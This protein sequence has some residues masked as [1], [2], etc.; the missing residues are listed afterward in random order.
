MPKGSYVDVIKGPARRLSGTPR[1]LKIE[2]SLVE[3]LLADIEDG[4]NKDALPLLAFTLERLYLEYGAGGDLQLSQY[5]ELRGVHGSIEA[6]VERALAAAD[7]DSSIPKDRAQRLALLRRGLIP[8]LAGIDPDSG[9]P[10][11]RVARM[12]EIPTESRRLVALLVEQRLLAIDAIV[13][14]DA[15]SGLEKPIVTIEP[16]HEALLRQWDE[17]QTWLVEDRELLVVMD[18]VKRAAR[19]W[20]KN[21]RGAAW[22]TH[23]GARLKAAETLDRRPDLAASLDDVDRAYLAECATAEVEARRRIR[24]TRATLGG[25]AFFVVAGVIAW[26]FETYL[27]DGLHWITVVRPY[28]ARQVQPYVLTSAAERALKPGDGFRE[29]AS[30]AF[31]PDMIVLPVG[32]FTMGSSNTEEGRFVNEGPQHK[33]SI[34]RPFAVSK[35]DVT[36]DDWDACVAVGG[37]PDVDELDVWSR[38][39]AAD[40]RDLGR[41][42]ALCGLARGDDGQALSLAHRGG[43]GICGSRRRDDGLFMGRSNRRGEGQLHRLRQQVGQ[44]RNLAGRIV[45]FQTRSASTIWPAMSGNGCRTAG[46][47]ITAA[48]QPT[49]RS[50]PAATATNMSSGVDPGWPSRHSFDRHSE[51]SF[52]P[53]ST[54]AILVFA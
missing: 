5:R 9:A 16:A 33:I 38:A 1:A 19:E 46:T 17:L 24:R 47:T 51:V 40:Q 54:I 48:R 41:G 21:D 34:A 18:N 28:I 2:D 35:F 44:A 37:C 29:C 4:S 36:F 20:E 43:M 6:A 25:L 12:S 42:A 27:K 14:K 53:T 15:L 50:G 49:A 10:R 7:A 26:R 39:K 3:Q 23:E 45:R 52:R 11:R 30:D 32:E 8:W 13:A 31:C 22:L